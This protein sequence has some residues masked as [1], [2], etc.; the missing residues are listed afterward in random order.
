MVKDAMLPWGVKVDVAAARTAPPGLVTLTAETT[1]LVRV[2]D[3]V[4]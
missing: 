3:A 4:A 2:A 1:S